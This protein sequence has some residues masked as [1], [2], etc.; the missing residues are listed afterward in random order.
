MPE[1]DDLPEPENIKKKTPATRSPYKPSQE[2]KQDQLATI[3]L[4]LKELETRMKRV[5]KRLFWMSMAGYIKILFIV[6][7]IIFGL[8]YL[9][10]LISQ[11]TAAFSSSGEG[12]S[13]FDAFQETLNLL[14]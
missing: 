4:Q 13:V 10:S 7:P 9:P 3:S 8:L 2:S 12:T 11:Y 1:T 5:D 6:V 14:Q